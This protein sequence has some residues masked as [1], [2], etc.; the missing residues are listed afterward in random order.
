MLE[1]L[2]EF[3]DQKVEVRLTNGKKMRCIPQQYLE[4][5]YESYLVDVYESYG[6]YTKG[7]LVELT[8]KEIEEVIPL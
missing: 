1:K 2:F 3:E 8:E 4:E 5:D 7:M 6:G